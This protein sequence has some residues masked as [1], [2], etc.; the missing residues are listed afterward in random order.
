MSLKLFY[1]DEVFQVG[2]DVDSM[3]IYLCIS[4]QHNGET[5]S[6]KLR[7]EEYNNFVNALLEAQSSLGGYLHR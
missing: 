6:V 1:E 4:G 2:V 7:E 5:V 3:K